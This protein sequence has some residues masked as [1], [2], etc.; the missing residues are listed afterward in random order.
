MAQS[1]N[2]DLWVASS[3]GLFR[4]F[5]Q[6]NQLLI[7]KISFADPEPIIN[8][9]MFDTQDT[10]WI[11][12]NDGVY[13]RFTGESSFTHFTP[14]PEEAGSLAGQLVTAL[15]TDHQD[16]IWIGT[17][18]GGLNRYLPSTNNFISYTSKDGLTGEM[19]TCIQEDEQGKLW[20][21]TNRGLSQFDP[22]LEIFY[23]YDS[24]DGLQEGEFISCTKN[25]DG[26]L[27]FGGLRGLN[28]FNPQE[29]QRNEQ[30]PPV[31]I[32]QVYLF[33]QPYNYDL[34]P[35]QRLQ[36][37]Y[38]Q[39]FLA[40]DFAALDFHAPQKNQYAFKLEGLDQE[41]NEIGSRRYAEYPDLKPGEYTFRVIASNNDGVW[42]EEGTSVQIS[43][44]P[45]LW[46]TNWFQLAAAIM[47]A[48]AVYGGYRLQLRRLRERS[49]AL[50]AEVAART[51]D[52]KLRTREAEQR[53]AEIEA[54]YQA[55][56]E[57]YRYLNLE[58]VL[59]ALLDTALEIMNADKALLVIWD[60]ARASMEVY[61]H[62]GF[63][64]STINEFQI[65]PGEGHYGSPAV[66]GETAILEDTT[67]DPDFPQ[68][69]IQDEQIHTSA[70]VPIKIDAII[71]GVFSLEYVEHRSITNQ[72]QRLL[73]AL[74]QRT[75]I[76]IENARLYEQAQ[77]LAALE[78]RTRIAR[79]LHDSVTQTLF[80]T[81]MFADTA[82]NLLSSGNYDSAAEV[83]RKLSDTAR[84]AL[85]EMRL[86]IYELRPPVLEKE[87]LAS[88]LI[89]RL[90][91]V[92]KRAGIQ[93]ELE[94]E[95][96]NG[97]SQDE[98]QQIY[99]I[100]IEALNNILK[101]AEAEHVSITLM[102]K[103]D[104][105]LLEIEDDGVGF[106]SEAAHESGGLGIHGMHERAARIGAQLDLQSE[107]DHGTRLT[108]TM[109]IQP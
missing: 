58:H 65:N 87:G 81:S 24:R 33:N 86:L 108:V 49:Q 4:L 62:I 89:S 3:R 39:N 75:A 78:E 27:Y 60:D 95:E 59:N 57:L 28:A 41:W 45:P 104:Q 79:D 107:A 37:S 85:A 70:A 74:A 50:E 43:I 90:D 91:T 82:E 5:K 92:E 35:N 29:I 30:H 88:A 38:L 105:L 97:L 84:K 101:H 47:I 10:L 103:N 67:K 69:L 8:E 14:D 2:S 53:Q 71:F 11:A 83:I 20:L 34:Q 100:A 68:D 23:N 96:I 6:D 54:L 63:Q 25:M 109:E 40:F 36:F 19:V 42:N 44:R 106:D 102:Q 99:S 9:I 22:Q 48:G 72:E 46:Q 93:T 15:Y 66:S 1:K 17:I 26:Q 55:D 76:A 51:Q 52:L 18:F 12:T 94:I 31:V 77:E 80:G 13:V 61:T 7:E 64:T 73:E 16:Q 98:E 32:N 21:G 56:E